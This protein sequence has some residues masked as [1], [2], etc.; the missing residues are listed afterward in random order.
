MISLDFFRRN[1]P[2]A[3][4]H[5]QPQVILWGSS[6]FIDS[7]LPCLKEAGMRPAFAVD[8]CGL[9]MPTWTLPVK[10]LQQFRSQAQQST[11]T[12]IVALENRSGAYAADPWAAALDEIKGQ[13]DAPH[14]VVDP[15]FICDRLKY[16]YRGRAVAAGF[17]GS[18][19]A[20]IQAIIDRLMAFEPRSWTGKEH[21]LSFLVGQRIQRLQ[22]ALS[23]AVERAGSTVEYS[24]LTVASSDQVI[25][26][27]NTKEK[28][29]ILL[30]DV[31]SRS[32]MHSDLHRTHQVMDG[33]TI[34]YFRQ[35]RYEIF[36][37]IR[38]PLDILTSVA[39]KLA[40]NPQRML[41]DFDWFRDVA[42]AV[43]RY[44]HA[45]ESSGDD[46]HLIRYEDLIARPL[47]IIRRI[48][49]ALD[50]G[51][52]EEQARQIWDAVGFKLLHR[53][54]KHLW[55]PGA[56][57]WRKY[58]TEDHLAIAREL[59]IMEIVAGHG[60]DPNVELDASVAVED[61]S[62]T[63]QDEKITACINCLYLGL[64]DIPRHVFHPDVVMST[65]SALQCRYMC[66][67]PTTRE[68]VRIFE[69][70]VATQS[71]MHSLSRWSNEGA[72]MLC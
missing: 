19:N 13:S 53:N 34:D 35:M 37:S 58:L 66:T 16:D 41:T 33:Q 54:P 18:G 4:R 38:H 6:N 68:A 64:Y 29:Q 1:Q 36:I 44:F 30:L 51:C 31:P 12:P 9:G 2:K 3:L 26:Q 25:V 50:I 71:L 45:F 62:E 65:S 11:D 22:K 39:R 21:L 52:S 57:K 70:S 8:P 23:D 15:V 49:A 5:D 69:E 27:V 46:L 63:G 14:R 43:A 48:A 24:S 72:A 67:T 40:L 17:P 60:Y 56:G 55:K 7:Y 10:S 28:G 32:H 20:V 61:R 42:D 59:G 47:E